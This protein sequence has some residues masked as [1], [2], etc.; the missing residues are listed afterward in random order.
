MRQLSA[1][2][3]EQEELDYALVSQLTILSNAAEAKLGTT[4]AIFAGVASIT[5]QLEVASAQAAGAAVLG[6]RSAKAKL[7][8]AASGTFLVR[9]TF[10]ARHREDVEKEE[11]EETQNE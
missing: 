2:K 11:R 6:R 10:L 5:A 7:A 1:T 3:C 9:A 8:A 4:G